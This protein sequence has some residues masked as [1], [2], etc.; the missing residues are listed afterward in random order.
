ML[1]GFYAIQS[2]TVGARGP[3]AQSHLVTTEAAAIGTKQSKIACN[4]STMAMGLPRAEAPRGLYNGLSGCCHFRTMLTL[5][6][7]PTI[8]NT[9]VCRAHFQSVS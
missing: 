8:P 2:R 4:Y 7:G 6:C 1:N 3:L 9:N 5:A